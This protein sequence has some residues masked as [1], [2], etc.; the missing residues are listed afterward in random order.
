MSAVKPLHPDANETELRAWWMPF[1]HNRYFKAAPRLIAS[2]KGCYFT[3]T[4]GRRLFDCLSGLWCVPGSLASAR[5]A[6][7]KRQVDTLDYAPSF[8]MGHEPAFRLATRITQ[9]AGRVNHRVFFVNSGSEAVTRRS[10][11]PWPTSYA[12]RSLQDAD[13]R[14]ERGPPWRGVRWHFDWRHCVQPQDVRAADDP[15]SRPPA[16]YLES[17]RRWPTATVTEPGAHPAEELEKSVALH[18]ASTIAGSSSSRC[19]ARP[20]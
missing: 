18:D 8:Q 14:R 4:D 17:R 7:I 5:G 3:L 12:R 19:R 10:R 11:S 13:H 15:W 2:A 16:T 9:L 6:A 1:T 20:A